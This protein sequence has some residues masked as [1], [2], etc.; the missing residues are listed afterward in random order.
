MT[1]IDAPTPPV[2]TFERWMAERE[3]RNGGIVPPW[4]LPENEPRVPEQPPVS[5]TSGTE[6]ASAGADAHA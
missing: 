5:R 4:L 2:S 1:I 6:P 3:R